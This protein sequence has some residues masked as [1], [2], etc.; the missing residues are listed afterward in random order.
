MVLQ[1]IVGQKYNQI[2]VYQYVV[3]VHVK[4]SI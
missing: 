3:H 1:V 2:N 4:R